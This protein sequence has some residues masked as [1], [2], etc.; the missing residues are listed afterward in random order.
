MLKN[1]KVILFVALK[2]WS[3]RKLLDPTTYV[4]VQLIIQTLNFKNRYCVPKLE[5]LSVKIERVPLLTFVNARG[6]SE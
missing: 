5:I 3:G 4:G 2:S 1:N 6:F